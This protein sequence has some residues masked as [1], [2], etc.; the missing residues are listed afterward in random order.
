MKKYLYIF[1]TI[2]I[3]GTV[4]FALANAAEPPIPPPEKTYPLNGSAVFFESFTGPG[5]G[6]ITLRWDSQDGADKGY[7][8]LFEGHWIPT[9]TN[10]ATF[11]TLNENTTYQWNVRSCW[12]SDSLFG[13]ECNDGGENFT[14]TATAAAAPTGLVPCG[15]GTAKPNCDLCDFFVLTNNII[16]EIMFKY[17]PIIAVL[18]LVIGGAFFFI[19]GAKPASF[20]KGKGIITSVVIGLLIIFSAWIMV[21]TV[22]TKS[23]VIE[24]PSLF[25]W[26][27]INCQ[28]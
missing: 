10:S 16:K 2:F 11:K 4:F 21:N 26:H 6:V 12:K 7:Q 14:F 17:V 15:P 18:M 3:G 28:I 1:L 20:E 27:Q 23:G 19:S 24:S 22:L 25:Q 8:V 5:S 13:L 9:I